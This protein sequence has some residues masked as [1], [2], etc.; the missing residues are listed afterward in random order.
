MRSAEP[1]N[2][3]EA[4]NCTRLQTLG[5]NALGGEVHK[6]M[7]HQEMLRQASGVNRRT[8]LV[9]IAALLSS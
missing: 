5:M 3:Q 1:E 2:A 4:R 6:V 7:A 9:G 8:A